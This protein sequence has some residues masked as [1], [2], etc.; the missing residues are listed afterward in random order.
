MKHEIPERYQRIR[1]SRK[2]KLTE[3]KKPVWDGPGDDVIC[4]ARLDYPGGPD[5]ILKQLDGIFS[6]AFIALHPFMHIDG[7]N[8]DNSQQRSIEIKRSDIE[9]KLTLEAL[10]EFA[11]EHNK[12]RPYDFNTFEQFEKLV[13]NKR[14]WSEVGKACRLPRLKDVSRAIL[15]A[16]NSLNEENEDR[17][18]AERL[19]SF[20]GEENLFWP[21]RGQFPSSLDN[22]IAETM[23]RLR[24]ENVYL[25]DEFGYASHVKSPDELFAT[26]EPWS[27]EYRLES[28]HPI[29]EI[30]SDTV[31]V[32][33]A[34]NF[35]SHFTLICG[36]DEL[37]S[38]ELESLFEGFWCDA[39]TRFC[40]F[41]NEGEYVKLPSS[42]P[43]FGEIIEQN[44]LEYE[45]LIANIA[46]SESDDD[47]V[48]S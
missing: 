17:E 34:A 19:S 27:Q 38:I 30:F 46:A 25:R 12:E 6:C 7:L 36:Y 8:P 2:V 21:V 26:I 31:T 47:S 33:F 5:P 10:E 23:R 22:A 35:E 37:K 43:T 41:L 15:T 39:T 32:R 3:Q 11:E 14:Q 9:G 13:G 45:A 1:K 28:N 44:T 20:C 4:D 40:W 42:G 16:T 24:V 18:G 48:G 29:R